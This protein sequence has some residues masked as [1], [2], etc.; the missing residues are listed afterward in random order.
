[1]KIA[2]CTNVF[3]ADEFLPACQRL[4]AL[5]YDAVELWQATLETWRPEELKAH[6]DDAGLRVAQLCPYFDFTGG[7]ADWERSLREAARFVELARVY[8]TP[9][10][11]VF[12]GHV[13]SNEAVEEQWQAAVWGLR[14]ACAL[15]AEHGLRFAVEAHP[16]T[17]ADSSLSI[18]RL[19][20]EVAAPNLGLNLQVP[21]GD[22]E[23][24]DSARQ[25]APWVI[26]L[27][28]HNWRGPAPRGEWECLTMLDDGDLNFPAFLRIL[29]RAGFDGYVSI[30]HGTHLGRDDMWQV[31]EHEIRYLRELSPKIEAEFPVE[32]ASR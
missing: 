32:Q 26:H 2:F 23:P 31:A 30:E 19:L 15:G 21:I 22:E 12:T 29:R 28:A 10:I 3:S 14:S 6:L 8:D 5:G 27:H 11:R 1:M 9:L 4:A 17:L 16:G 24:L 13:G 7:R 18:Q 25:L 20:D